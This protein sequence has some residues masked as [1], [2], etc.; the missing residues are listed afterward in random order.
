MA[1]PDKPTRGTPI[2]YL[3]G[4]STRD[5]ETVH[6]N[7]VEKTVEIDKSIRT[8]QEFQAKCLE[9][10]DIAG[11]SVCPASD[12]TEAGTRFLSGKEMAI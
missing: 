6:I 5:G 11:F 9:D 8:F 2:N 12:V 7:A 3:F 4:T 1:T 10:Q